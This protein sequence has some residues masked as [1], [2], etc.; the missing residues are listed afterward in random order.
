VLR[1]SRL[2]IPVKLDRIA[3]TFSAING[4]VVAGGLYV[5]AGAQFGSD[6]LDV[7]LNGLAPVPYFPSPELNGEARLPSQLS[8]VQVLFDGAPA[9]ILLT[10][11]GHR[12]RRRSH[13]AC[14]ISL[15]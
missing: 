4:G 15:P 11:T 14:R 2:E 13:G 9:P 3:N 6:A 10:S 7:T 12:D 5:T 1:L 8:G